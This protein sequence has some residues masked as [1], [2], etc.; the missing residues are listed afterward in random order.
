MINIW[1]IRADY[2]INELNGQKL[3]EMITSVVVD[4]FCI[5]FKKSIV[6]ARVCRRLM[7]HDFVHR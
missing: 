4:K 6:A 3:F 1:K 7:T 2:H 5:P